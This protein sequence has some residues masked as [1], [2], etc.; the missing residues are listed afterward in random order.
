MFNDLFGVKFKYGGKS[1]EEGFDC[2]NLCREVY[3]RIGKELPTFEYVVEEIHGI[4]GAKN[5]DKKIAKAKEMFKKLERPEPYCLVTFF[6]RPPYTSHIGVV[7]PDC[8]HFIHIMEKTSVTIER[9]DAPEWERRITGFW[10][11]QD[12]TS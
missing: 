4:E 1:I 11:Y 5:I 10:R 9:L 6:I 12:V 2:W 8:L 3:R 7:L